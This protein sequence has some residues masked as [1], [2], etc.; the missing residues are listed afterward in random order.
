[1]PFRESPFIRL[2]EDGVEGGGNDAKQL[3][4]RRKPTQEEDCFQVSKSSHMR[5]ILREQ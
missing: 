5:S 2:R 1:M 4:N 3:T